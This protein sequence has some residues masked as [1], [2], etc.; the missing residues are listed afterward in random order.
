MKK[1]LLL[2]IL[3]AICVTCMAFSC[4]SALTSASFA[5]AASNPE[6]TLALGY[7][8]GKLVTAQKNFTA[9][10]HGS[11]IVSTDLMENAFN[12][13]D[14]ESYIAITADSSTKFISGNNGLTIAFRMATTTDSYYKDEDAVRPNTTDDFEQFFAVQGENG[15]TAYICAGG[16]YYRDAS[17]TTTYAQPGGNYKVYITTT[18]KDVIF[19][20]NEPDSDTPITSYLD[21]TRKQRYQSTNSK[22]EVIKKVSSLFLSV[23]SKEGATLYVR[24]PH[25]EKTN[26]NSSTL[27]ISNVNVYDGILTTAQMSD[28]FKPFEDENENGGNEGSEPTELKAS[29]RYN[30]GSF[31]ASEGYTTSFS[32]SGIVAS[33]VIKNGFNFSDITSY[34]TIKADA[35]TRFISGVDGVTFTFKQASTTNDYF[36]DDDSNSIRPNGTDIYEQLLSFEDANGNTAY[37]CTGGLYYLPAGGSSTYAQPNGLKGYKKMLTTEAKHIAVTVSADATTILVYINGELTQQ[38]TDSNNRADKIQLV[39]ECILASLSTNGSSMH[40]R[41]PNPKKTDRNSTTLIVADLDIYNGVLTEDAIKELIKSESTVTPPVEV[42][43]VASDKVTVQAMGQG[44]VAAGD[45][46]HPNAYHLNDISTYIE[47]APSADVALSP[48]GKALS[49]HFWHKTTTNSYYQNEGATRPNTTDDYEQLFC[50]EGENGVAAYICT[51]GIYFDDGVGTDWE[52][53]GA[54]GT[55]KALMNTNWKYVSIV[56]DS[57]NL[58]IYTYVNG[59]LAQ[60][61]DQTHTKKEIV[62]KVVNLFASA[63]QT[64]GSKLY[65]RKPFHLRTTRNSATN[66]IEGLTIAEGCLT[67]EQAL[68]FYDKAVGNS[69]I[70]V[71]ANVDIETATLLGK[72]GDVINV[73]EASI[74]GFTFE[75]LFLDENHTTALPAGAVFSESITTL[76]AKYSPIAYSI[77]YNLNGATQNASNPASYTVLNNG[78]TILPVEKAGYT[79]GGWYRTEDFRNEFSYIVPGLVGDIELYAK[80]T[81]NVYSVT[82]ILNGGLLMGA[83]KESYTVEDSAIALV[84]AWKPDYNFEGWYSDAEF[85]NKVESIDTSAAKDLTLYAKYSPVVYTVT[86]VAEGATHENTVTSY[87]V[88]DS[89]I[90]LLDAVKAN[91]TFAGWY[92]DA[93]FTNKVEAINTAL[94]TDLTLCAKFTANAFTITYVAEGATHENA[95]SYT[96]EDSAIALLDAVKANYNFDGWYSDAE[97]TAKVEAIDTTAAA[98]LTLYAKFS[99]VA[100]TVTYIAEGATH[101]NA[102]SYTVEDEG[103]ALLDAIKEGYT[104]DGWY[105]DAEFTTKVEAIDTASATDLTLYAKFTEIEDRELLFACYS[106]M[107]LSS[108]LFAVAI[109]AI[110]F[111]IKKRGER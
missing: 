45:S 16:I 44:F 14:Q 27:L 67:A 94:A 36:E 97:F 111:L 95:T 7:K 60:Y 103:F 43:T 31:T 109:S 55:I 11:G 17:G 63:S 89:S 46:E 48:N 20:I 53:A 13:A 77:T 80:F 18:A 70:K 98:D 59:E 15:D 74:E 75:G 81:A 84:N 42:Q 56:V 57:K 32:G 64:K 49:F 110:A 41:K 108:S 51:G 73:T 5:S 40:I 9:T 79:F 58:A 66:I 105:S 3:S 88:E 90:A 72:I 19:T 101:E 87:T 1:P 92:S 100:Y 76:Y 99:P 12:I 82:Y 96:V 86:Y 47:I 29:L 91:Y 37:I 93:E 38:Y 26:R 4:V 50:V 33:S 23:L 106:S 28:M 78:V 2:K 65:F 52:Y 62:A 35:N 68:S 61:Y 54:K 24:K 71:I 107:A 34:A 69:R 85:T 22:I 30:N 102:T 104:F 10:A 39:A 25:P 83:V 8:N 21:A 6:P